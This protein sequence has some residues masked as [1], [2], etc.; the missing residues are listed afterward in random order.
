MCSNQLRDLIAQFHCG[1]SRRVRGQ[2]G[3]LLARGRDGQ[4]NLLCLRYAGQG[5]G[6]GRQRRWCWGSFSLASLLLLGNRSLVHGCAKRTAI[7]PFFGSAWRFRGLLRLNLRP[8]VMLRSRARS[9]TY[10]A[11][12]R[13][14]PMTLED[15]QVDLLRKNVRSVHHQAFDLE[16]C[17]ALVKFEPWEVV[18]ET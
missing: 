9:A 15:S 13:L 4:L 5:Q 8:L 14:F 3:C 18:P 12:T 1:R 11:S 10:L 2:P 7:S 6:S 16:L 17:Q